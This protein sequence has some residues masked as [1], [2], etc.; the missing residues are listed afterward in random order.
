MY[1]FIFHFRKVKFCGVTSYVCLASCVV[2]WVKKHL[3]TGTALAGRVVP[4]M[5]TLVTNHMRRRLC[6]T[7][8]WLLHRYT[9]VASGETATKPVRT[10]SD[11]IS[12]GRTEP[13]YMSTATE[14]II[15]GN[16]VRTVLS[17]SGVQSRSLTPDM[18]PS[19]RKKKLIRHDVS[20]ISIRITENSVKTKINSR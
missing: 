14:C 15:T 3:C 16:D 5:G 20:R 18:S 13:V 7:N 2:L 8:G 11:K 6:Q 9:L 12:R 1:S 10:T 17:C 4:N 19:G